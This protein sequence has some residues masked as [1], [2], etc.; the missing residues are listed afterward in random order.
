MFVFMSISCGDHSE[1]SWLQMLISWT[2]LFTFHGSR[3]KKQHL[4]VVLLIFPSEHEM[5]SKQHTGCLFFLAIRVPG[6]QFS[7]HTERG[8]WKKENILSFQT[9]VKYHLRYM[10]YIYNYGAV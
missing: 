10:I 6:G 1:L 7:L 2:S 4:L 3:Q 8:G 9:S 5:Q